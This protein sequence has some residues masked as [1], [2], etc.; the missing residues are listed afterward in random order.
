MTRALFICGKARMRSP[1]AAEIARQWVE[2]DYAGLSHDADVAIDHDAVDW[3]DIILV[4]EARQA[5]RLKTLFPDLSARKTIVNLGIPDRYSF[6]QP[7]LVTRLT[8]I[9]RARFAT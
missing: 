9:L 6:M 4:M 2:T 8:P 1:T 7:E 3:A 5:K